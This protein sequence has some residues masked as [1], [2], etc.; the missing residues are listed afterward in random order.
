MEN[1]EILHKAALFG[2]VNDILSVDEVNRNGSIPFCT[3]DGRNYEVDIVRFKSPIFEN[4]QSLR[5]LVKRTSAH[6]NIHLNDLKA[7]IK[8]KNIEFQKR[9]NI[10]A[11]KDLIIQDDENVLMKIHDNVFWDMV[12]NELR[13]DIL[14]SPYDEIYFLTAGHMIIPMKKTL[15]GS[16]AE[17]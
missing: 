11:T 4:V 7:I 15:N 9:I 8:R 12:Q 1:S 10:K 5:G 3:I 17:V 6:D 14:K 13:Q 2:Y 16:S